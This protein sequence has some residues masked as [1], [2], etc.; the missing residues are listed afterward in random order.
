MRRFVCPL[1]GF[2]ILLS[3]ASHA[4]TGGE[5]ARAVI[6][7]AIKATGGE[8]AL[9]KHQASTFKEKGTYYGM[10]DG[11][12]YTGNS[13]MQFPDQFRMEIV[14]VFMMV[15]NGDKGW[16][17][18]EKGVMEMTKEQL[19]EQ[20]TNLRAGWMV[21][22]LPLKDK[23]YTLKMLPA[24][25]VEGAEA[26]VVLATRKDYP[27]VKIYIDKKTNLVVKSEHKSKAADL[28]GK[29]VMMTSYYSNFKEVDGAKMPF[30]MIMKRDGERFIE[31]EVLEMKAH[32]KLDA[33]VFAMP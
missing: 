10:G 17:K 1:V 30:K 22:L 7:S 21:S 11:L 27:D 28:K 24:E 18:S 23:A 8:Q 3:L 33:K 16:M 26:N 19:A 31:S 6:E 20:R 13:A 29:E 25:K 5:D 2:A 15:V 9:A 12:P 4:W 14:N 32:G